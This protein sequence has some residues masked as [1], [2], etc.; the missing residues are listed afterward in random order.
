MPPHGLAFSI[1]V[2]KFL[3]A[4][5]ALSNCVAS[6]G[7][8]P[9]EPSRG[10]SGEPDALRL[11]AILRQGELPAG[12]RE[13]VVVH[14]RARRRAPLPA[15]LVSPSAIPAPFQ[16]NICLI[17]GTIFFFKVEVVSHEAS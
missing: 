8:G 13:R 1:G 16:I 7:R 14:Q 3:S 5:M 10:P 11:Q 2:G 6:P 15:A 4:G 17:H 12:Q 9:P